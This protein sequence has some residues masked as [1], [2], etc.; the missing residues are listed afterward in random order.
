MTSRSEEEDADDDDK[1]FLKFLHK[2]NL[3]KLGLLKDTELQQ[4]SYHM[5]L[6]DCGVVLTVNK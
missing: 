4:A 2:L 6:V 3:E 5:V 1:A